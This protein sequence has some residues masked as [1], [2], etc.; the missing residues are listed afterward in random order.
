[1][2]PSWWALLLRFDDP[3]MPIV[4]AISIVLGFAK[5]RLAENVSYGLG[6]VSLTPIG[7]RAAVVWAWWEAFSVGIAALFR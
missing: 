4:G 7:G 1:M 3:L 5:V 2:K 6:R